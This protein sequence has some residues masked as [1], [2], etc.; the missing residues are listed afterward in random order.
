MGIIIRIPENLFFYKLIVAKLQFMV[1]APWALGSS[2]L[3]SLGSGLWAL[4]SGLWAPWALGSGQDVLGSRVYWAPE[5]T[6]LP[7]LPN[8]NLLSVFEVFSPLR[9]FFKFRIWTKNV[10]RDCLHNASLK[11]W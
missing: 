1:W 10:S 4:G 5:I 11:C 8:R 2:A 9:Q 3:G 7:G 6:G